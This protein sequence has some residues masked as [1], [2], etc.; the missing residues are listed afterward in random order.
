MKISSRITDLETLLII[1][2][3]KLN[4]IDLDIENTSNTIEVAVDSSQHSIDKENAVDARNDCG[5]VNHSSDSQPSYQPNRNMNMNMA[6][7]PLTQTR[8][9]AAK[10]YDT[11]TVKPP[12]PPPPPP[13]PLPQGSV[14]ST[15]ALPLLFQITFLNGKT[16]TYSDSDSD[17]DSDGVR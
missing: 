3:A 15:L 9:S 8:T 11:D 1:F 5:F 10:E 17:S 2:E 6:V 12:Q 16:N 13:P 7:T 14:L 4:S